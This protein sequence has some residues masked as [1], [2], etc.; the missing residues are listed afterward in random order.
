L[1]KAGYVLPEHDSFSA[2]TIHFTLTAT[3]RGALAIHKKKA[4][5]GSRCSRASSR[6][7]TQLQ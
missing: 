4:L 1:T 3:G 6:K 5:R 2:D 7:R